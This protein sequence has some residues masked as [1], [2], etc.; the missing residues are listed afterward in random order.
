MCLHQKSCALQRWSALTCLAL[1]FP[2]NDQGCLRQAG[3]PL[4]AT[5]LSNGRALDW[6]RHSSVVDE[7]LPVDVSETSDGQ[8]SLDDG[9]DVEVWV[10]L[11]EAVQATGV[12]DKTLRRWLSKGEVQG[13]EVNHQFG[14][15]WTVLLS[16]VKELA[17]RKGIGHLRS[18]A[19]PS[20]MSTPD[21]GSGQGVVQGAPP[22]QMLVPRTEW[23]R[24]VTQMA[25]I[26]DLAAELGEAKEAKG[27]AE[28]KLEV[29]DERL[30]STREERDAARADRDGARTELDATL[31]RL[32][33]LE[34][35]AAVVEALAKAEA[36]KSQRR[37]WFRRRRDQR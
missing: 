10:T 25:N 24:A 29:I 7:V 27:R 23:E 34:Q 3:H 11:S 20:D 2:I 8:P 6:G 9:N 22:G 14:V 13:R 36:E 4:L 32:K 35:E 30:K 37:S 21:Q 16:E 31:L 28:A 33:E 19:A 12:A 17:A 18:K 15:Q 26:A 1:D 5:T